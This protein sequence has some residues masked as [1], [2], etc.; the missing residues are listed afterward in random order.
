MFFAPSKKNHLPSFP[1]KSVP[2]A[3]STPSQW[4]EP[5]M[6]AA[7]RLFTSWTLAKT[8]HGCL[9]ETDTNAAFHWA[10]ELVFTSFPVGSFVPL[11]SEM[12]F[13]LG[14]SGIL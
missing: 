14:N 3:V 10:R 13:Q 12:Y 2:L 9:T 11:K 6:A 5:E 8:S 1:H 7:A 4:S